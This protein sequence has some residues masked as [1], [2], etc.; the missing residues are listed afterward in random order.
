MTPRTRVVALWLGVAFHVGTGLQLELG[1]FG[2]HAL[3]LYLPLV[4]WDRYADARRRA[5][6]ARTESRRSLAESPA[7]V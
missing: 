4:P 5:A 3:C 1:M 6:A 2:L 7:P